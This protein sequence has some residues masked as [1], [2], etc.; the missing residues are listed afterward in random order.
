LGHN[1]GLHVVAEGVEDAT[2]QDALTLIGCDLVQGY[3][4]RRPVPAEEL[5]G[6]LEVH[7]TP[8]SLVVEPR[9]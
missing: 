4:I 6:W 8:T 2:T 7:A 5:E 3:H 9:N 1:L